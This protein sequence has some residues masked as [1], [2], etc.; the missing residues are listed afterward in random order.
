MSE[1]SLPKLS[2]L[3]ARYGSDKHLGDPKA[4]HSYGPFYDDLLADRRRNVTSVLELGVLNGAS[5]RAWRD[6]FEGALVF[7]IDNGRDPYEEWLISCRRADAI[8]AAQLAEALG[9]RTFDLIV[10]DASHWESHQ[11]QSFEILRPRLRPRGLYVVEDI[12]HESTANKFRD[13]GFEIEDL[14]GLRMRHDDLLAVF[15]A[16]D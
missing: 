10:D 4:G 14:R 13:L 8:S 11:L 1:P 12:Q 3:F 2:E 7:G 5:L 9:D 6:F 15:R 16:P